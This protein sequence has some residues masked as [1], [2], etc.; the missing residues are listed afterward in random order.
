MVKPPDLS[1]NALWKQR[2][3]SPGVLWSRI[4]HQNPTRGLVCTNKDG[5]YQLYAWDVNNG[6]LSQLTIPVTGVFNGVLSPDGAVV[7]YHQDDVGNEIGHWVS[8]PFKG[9]D[10]EVITPEM[11]PYASWSL[12]ISQSGSHMG[13]T[14]AGKDGFKTF[15]WAED[16]A[17]AIIFES[18]QLTQGPQFSYNGE[19]VLVESTEKS[20][21]VETALLAFDTATGAQINE[22]WDG[23]GSGIKCHNFPPIPGD[24]RM[25]GTSSQ[26]G[27]E[28]PLIWNPQTDERHDLQLETIPGDV[29]PVDWS[30]DGQ[31]LLLRQLHQAVH[32]LFVYDVESHA[33]TKLNHPAGVYGAGYFVGNNEIYITWSDSTHPN[34]VIAL[35]ANTGEQTR[36][37][38]AAGDALPGQQWRSVMF[39]GANGEQIQ[40]WLATPE[41]EG[42]FP[43]ILQTHGGPTAVTTETFTP[44]SQAWLDHGFA[45]LTIN[46]HG[47]ITFGKDFEKS[48]WY[49]LGDLE[50]EDMAAAYHWLVD[51]RIAQ[52]NAVF[53][54]GGSYGGYLTLQAIG[55]KPD[56][57]AGGMAVVAIADWF[58]MYED[59]AESL[60]GYQRAMFGG[61]PEK[62]SRMPIAKVHLLPMPMAFRLP[63][64]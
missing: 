51:N 1:D 23:P 18:E 37:V 64:W 12:K 6:E 28:R 5:V 30:S 25:V 62:K 52:P 46:Y 38:L 14:A 44:G 34:R 35:D 43:T 42:P 33:V 16:A 50:V 10:P 13:F 15:I 36:E 45:Y 49:N 24:L 2:Y 21:T 3:R 22:L 60:R 4:A 9:G 8:V 41:G 32:Q 53:L 7:Y 19:I 20:G 54:T 61:T 11:P 40:G 57:W 55:K 48:I 39:A 47:S 29:Y 17:P 56:L 31:R 26:S 27:F 63:C 58:L 59:Q